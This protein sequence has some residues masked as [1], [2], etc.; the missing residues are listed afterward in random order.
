MAEGKLKRLI[1]AVSS[2]G[3]TWDLSEIEKIFNLKFWLY[4]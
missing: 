3:E 4:L 2:N 1:T